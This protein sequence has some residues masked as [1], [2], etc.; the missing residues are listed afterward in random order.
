MSFSCLPSEPNLASRLKNGQN[1]TK[2]ERR[3][4]NGSVRPSEPDIQDKTTDPTVM[5]VLE[6]P[7]KDE[8]ATTHLPH[9][10]EALT[11]N[12]DKLL[13]NTASEALHQPAR[14]LS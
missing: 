6:E 1:S 5:T 12:L 7:T 4:R 14:K 2:N 3:I 11:L 9:P 8:K 13:M 10:Q